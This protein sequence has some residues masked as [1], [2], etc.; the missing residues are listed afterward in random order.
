MD[1]KIPLYQV[2]A[3]A[4][5]PF[6]GNPAAICPLDDWLGADVMQSIALENNLSETAFLVGGDGAYDLRWF[7]PTC[8][9]DLCG[10]ATLASAHVVFNALE[11]DCKEV[12]FSTRSG[13]LIVKRDGERLLMSFPA[14]ENQPIEPIIGLAEAIGVEIEQTLTSTQYQMVVLGNAEMVEKLQPDIG[15]IAANVHKGELIVTA[16]GD[17][18]DFVSRFFAPGAGID[19]DPVTGSAHCQLVPY[20]SGRLG[21]KTLLARQLSARGGTLYC[22]DAGGRVMLGGRT[23]HFLEGTITI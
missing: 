22:E 19:E 18:C 7:T 15:F 3:F 17:D 16:P 4:E 10:H 11:I 14:I 6:S 9:M 20:W 5:R 13:D 12:C 2:D 23:I 8:E 21:K 1:T